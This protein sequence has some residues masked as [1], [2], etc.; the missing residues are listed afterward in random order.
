LNIVVI[1]FR[2]MRFPHAALPS[3]RNRACSLALV[4]FCCAAFTNALAQAPSLPRETS[5]TV[6]PAKNTAPNKEPAAAT[7]PPIIGL[8][9]APNIS[10]VNP[11]AAAPSEL[12][13]RQLWSELRLNNPQLA[14]LRE[15]YFSAKATVP[16]IA[17]PANPQVGLVWSGMPANS[18]LALGGANTPT[19]QYPNGISNN[20]AI[21]F[22]QPFQFP[23]KKSLG[24]R[25]CR[26][27]CRSTL[28]PK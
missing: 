25:Y 11:K 16:Q 23:G 12:D 2:S 9:T 22:A 13:L 4:L 15:S 10:S 17:A 19:S 5:V 18:P 1:N 8:S 26:Y 20:N 27:Q 21:S 14:A 7:T 3:Y 24:C 28:G 6:S